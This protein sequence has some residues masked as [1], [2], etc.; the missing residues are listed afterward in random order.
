MSVGKRPYS[1]QVETLITPRSVKALI[2]WETDG[3]LRGQNLGPLCLT[4]HIFNEPLPF[5]AKLNTSQS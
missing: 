1:R 4:V 3:V 2:D 5:W